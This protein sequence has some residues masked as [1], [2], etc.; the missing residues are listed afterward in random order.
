MLWYIRC[1]TCGDIISYE[2][3]KYY[4][5]VEAINNDP[6]KTKKEKEKEYSKLI[7]SLG[8]KTYC[9]RIRIMGLIPYHKIVQT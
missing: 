2:M 9:C 5:S 3:D 4:S 8:Y 7:D 6:H 1:P